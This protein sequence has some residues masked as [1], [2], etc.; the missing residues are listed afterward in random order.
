MTCTKCGTPVGALEVFPGGLCLS[1]Y[2]MTPEANE[3]ITAE[4]LAQMW[5]APARKGQA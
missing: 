5:G 3:P 1:C 2:A 4:Q